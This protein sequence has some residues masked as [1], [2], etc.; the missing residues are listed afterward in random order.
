MASWV[1]RNALKIANARSI[2]YI[3]YQFFSQDI[4]ALSSRLRGIFPAYGC[5]SRLFL[6]KNSRR[7]RRPFSAQGKY[8]AVNSRDQK[9]NCFILILIPADSAISII[10]SGTFAV[11]TSSC[12]LSSLSSRLANSLISDEDGLVNFV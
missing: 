7:H 5:Y 4:W 11:F 2:S 10:R 3:C 12:S 6:A 8:G 1:R 9:R